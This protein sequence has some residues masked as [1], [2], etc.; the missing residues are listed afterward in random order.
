MYQYKDHKE[1]LEILRKAGFNH[2][3]MDKIVRFRRNFA[4]GDMDRT[5]T[6]RRR[7]EFAR[8]LFLRGKLN[9]TGEQ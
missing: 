4:L 8:W 2:M 3:Q 5:P 7:L 1:A 9:E 6:E